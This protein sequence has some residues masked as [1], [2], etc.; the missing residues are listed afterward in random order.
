M[1]HIF[2]SLSTS[3]CPII[4]NY[5][6]DGF[7]DHPAHLPQSA[8]SRAAATIRAASIFRQKF[9]LGQVLPEATKEGPLCMDSWRYVHNTIFQQLI[10]LRLP[11]GCLTVLA[12]LVLRAVT[13]V[14]VMLS[15]A[16]LESLDTWLFFAEVD[17][18]E[19]I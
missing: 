12:F 11:D 17:S 4:A 7:E 16:I 10:E 9:K 8:V 1:S 2:V 3:S 5:H 19:S 13:G 14:S 15:K 18:G 6:P